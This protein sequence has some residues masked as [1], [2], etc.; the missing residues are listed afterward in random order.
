MIQ[1]SKH[2]FVLDG[3]T[4]A[5]GKVSVAVLS[6]FQEW[7]K[8]E[9]MRDAAR[10]AGLLPESGRKP[11]LEKAMELCASFS[12]MGAEA[13]PFLSSPRGLSQ[14]TYLALHPSS[15]RISP[16]EIEAK[17][18]RDSYASLQRAMLSMAGVVSPDPTQSQAGT[19]PTGTSSSST[20]PTA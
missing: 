8:S 1:P 6:Q 4:Y 11:V 3:V 20:S 2:E 16:E 13:T 19:R 5:I 7:C 12:I 9:I 14:M 18:D 10:F 15:P 17:L